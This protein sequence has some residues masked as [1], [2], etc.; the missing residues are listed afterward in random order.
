MQ[1][2]Y[3]D[4]YG[5]KSRN[6]ALEYSRYAPSA[7]FVT[8]VASGALA[9]TDPWIQQTWISGQNRRR[10]WVS[11]G[12]TSYTLTVIAQGEPGEELVVQKGLV[13]R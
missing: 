2:W 9:T 7:R 1:G 13:A 11:A 6:W 5:S 8:L 4:S 12:L 10:I 3:S